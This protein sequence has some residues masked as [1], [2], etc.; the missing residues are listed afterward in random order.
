MDVLRTLFDWLADRTYLVVVL[1]TLIDATGIPFP[2]RVLLAAAGAVAAAGRADVLLIVALGAAAAALVDQIWYL[3]IT[4]GS[5]RLV[6]AYCRLRHRRRG[7]ADDAAAYFRRYGA[8]TIV[9]GRFFTSVRLLAW[10]FAAANGIG[11]ARFMALDAVGAVAWA[12]TWV[13]LGWLVGDR[14]LATAQ[15]TGMWLGIGGGAL[16]VLL[17]APLALRWWQRRADATSRARRGSAAA[18]SPESPADLRARPR[19]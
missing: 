1:G 18:A 2:G 13:L 5:T 16:A 7:C 9:L 12:S 19:P 8:A 17:A 10:P 6:D 15:T 4:R 11:Y 3:T 14:W